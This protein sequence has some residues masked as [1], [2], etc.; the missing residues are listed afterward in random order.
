M[1]SLILVTIALPIGVWYGL[2][3]RTF[4]LCKAAEGEFEGVWDDATKA[5]MTTGFLGYTKTLCLG[6]VGT[7][8]AES[9]TSYLA[10][11]DADAERCLRS[12][13]DSLQRNQ[14]SFLICG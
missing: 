8:R 7:R 9:S 1:I 11:L 2:R 14:K 5:S 4:Q 13:I 12:Q 6:N 10:R 3:Y